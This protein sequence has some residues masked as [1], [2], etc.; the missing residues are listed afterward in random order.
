[1]AVGAHIVT[2][3]PKLVAKYSKEG[4]LDDFVGGFLSGRYVVQVSYEGL[5][6]VENLDGGD[7]PTTRATPA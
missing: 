7:V 6:V 3:W 1:M 5:T 2:S 4:P